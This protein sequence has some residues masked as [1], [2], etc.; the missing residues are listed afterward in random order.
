MAE[1]KIKGRIFLGRF[2]DSTV[3]FTDVFASA[4]L[5][6]TCAFHMS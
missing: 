2:S 3:G 6:S 4:A 1:E 5:F